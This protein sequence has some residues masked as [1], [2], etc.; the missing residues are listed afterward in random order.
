MELEIAI[1]ITSSA[2][3]QEYAEGDADVTRFVSLMK[4]YDEHS[5]E[6]ALARCGESAV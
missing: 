3:P 6:R 2:S 5:A 1:I 4:P